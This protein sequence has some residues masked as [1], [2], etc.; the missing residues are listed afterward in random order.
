[1]LL[2]LLGKFSAFALHFTCCISNFQRCPKSDELLREDRSE[3]L[4]HLKFASIKGAACTLQNRIKKDPGLSNLKQT[5]TFLQL[6]RLN[7]SNKKGHL[8][9]RLND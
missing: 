5:R 8:S 3:Y 9:E 1:M 7:N 4:L 6:I 2:I